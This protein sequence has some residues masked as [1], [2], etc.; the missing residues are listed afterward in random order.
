MLGLRVGRTLLHEARV[1][2][3]AAIASI[4]GIL[5][6]GDPPAAGNPDAS[7]MLPDSGGIPDSGVPIDPR[8]RTEL[9]NP[10]DLAAITSS[11]AGSAVK[12][13]APVEGAASF[14]PLVAPCYFQNM[15]LYPWHLQ[16]LQSFPEHR[17]LTFD[18]YLALVLR[19]ASRLLWGGAIKAWPGARH[20]S[21]NARGVISYAV[22]SDPN[23][24]K[25]EDI[26]AVD[27]RLKQCIPFA[28]D[29]LVFVPEGTDQK[30][31]LTR[32][33]V[34]LKAEGVESL[35][36]EDL[37]EG[38]PYDPY[39]RG[40]NY[41]IL[42]IV[43]EGQPLGDYGP[44]DVV[45]VESAPNDISIVSG[46]ISK[47]P[48]NPLGHVNL[49]L[50]EKGIPN[51]AVP[52]IYRAAWIRALDKSLVHL[53]VADDRF[54]LEPA[55]LEDAERYWEAHRPRVRAPE[56][57]LTKK[58]PVSFETLRAVDRLAFG[59]KAANLGEL[60]SILEP[61]NRTTG[62]GIPLSAYDDF[63]R[64][65]NLQAEVDR[66]STDP[67]MKTDP[68]YKKAQLK[69]L[70]DQIKA[71]AIDPAFFA[72]V[73]QQIEA[74]NGRT[75][76]WKFRSSTNVE[77]LDELSGAGLYDSKSGCLADDLD[78]D[79]QGPSA[80]LTAREAEELQRQLDARRAEFTQYPDR[81][82]LAAI[83]ADLEGDLSEEKEV[84]RALKKVWSS[85]WN[86]RAYDEREYYGIDHRKAFMAMAVNPSFVLER[87]NT[88]AVSH[89]IVDAGAPLYRLNSQVGSESVVQPADP[90]A[91]AE[92]LTFRRE[93]GE[94][95]DIRLELGSSLLPPGQEVLPR[96]KLSELAHVLFLVHD[97][98]AAAVYPNI[99]PLSLD[100]EI[101]YTD[102]GEVVIKQARPYVS[103]D[104]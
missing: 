94:P 45:I 22:Y 50:R 3:R 33:R 55:R 79:L 8:F 92:L 77:D 104:P 5:A 85:L 6:C 57:D 60:H 68:T 86:L 97:H 26:I 24:L 75:Q 54:I 96:D 7:T 98:F 63:I 101:K 23:T 19:P 70:R 17:G 30:A 10:S 87:G 15:Y 36:P 28:A 43:P 56:A 61:K 16:F 93:N 1:R 103:Q 37:L 12:Y 40:E 90:T 41:G 67:R 82:Y 39:S 25:K 2:T 18:A 51:V 14:A 11:I 34:A 59:V 20:P 29:L 62:F 88:V 47:Q 42:S 48:Q 65:N 44:R 31:M 69:M 49:R 89:L 81:A 72:L 71:G 32:E 76:R 53:V 13:L 4:L 100:F 52:D 83:I 9:N 73:Q 64:Q 27:R 99:S 66:V 80:C 84:A 58:D 74:A 35:F 95:V 91:V 102:E 46:L 78:A 38:V 21:T